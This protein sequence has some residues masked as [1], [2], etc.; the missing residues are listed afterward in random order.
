MS[1]AIVRTTRDELVLREWCLV[2]T[3]ADISHVA[4]TAGG[5]HALS[6]DSAEAIRVVAMLSSYDDERR[7]RARARVPALNRSA[8]AAWM[9]ASAILVGHM[10]VGDV[11][12]DSVSFTRGAARAS[13]IRDG[14]LW[15]I[16][17]ALTLHS[18]AMHAI[19]NAVAGLLFLT[20]LCQRIGG[21]TAIALTALCGMAATF[22][23]AWVRSE[24]YTGIGASTAVFAALGLLAGV[25]GMRELPE[26]MWRRMRPIGA[27]V[28]ILAM[29]GASP[30]TD[31]AAH[32]LGLIAGIAAGLAFDARVDVAV[33]E[34]LDIAL[35][36]ATAA[37]FAAAWVIALHTP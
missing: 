32:I 21:G 22:V 12:M 25:R 5:V 8:N 28:A 4:Q 35:G 11:A 13:A 9:V 15:R 34:G 29:L 18:D 10:V 16:A 37:V 17:T 14:E 2:L 26:P 36:L 20:P 23:N 6:V 7:R 33:A 31:V 27:A 30:Q 24:G 1:G 3:A 19:S